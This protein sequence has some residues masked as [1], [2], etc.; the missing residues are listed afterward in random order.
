MNIN[1]AVRIFNAAN[2]K[3]FTKSA[4]KFLFFKEWFSLM[5]D[6][7]SIV[8]KNILETDSPLIQINRIVREVP[9]VICLRELRSRPTAKS[10]FVPSYEKHT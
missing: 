4:T 5:N 10:R 1:N 6:R 7:S 3:L 9:H 2:A 8:K